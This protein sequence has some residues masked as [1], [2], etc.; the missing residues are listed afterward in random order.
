MLADTIVRRCA[1]H[2]PLHRMERIYARDGITLSRQTICGWHMTLAERLEPL[3]DAMWTDALTA[4]YLCVDATGVLVQHADKCKNGHFFVVAAPEKHVLFGFSEKHNSKAVDA[5]IGG[6]QGDLVA[7]AHTVYDHLFLSGAVRE[8]GC[9]AHTR[10]YFYK[11]LGSEPQRARVALAYIKQLFEL[12]RGIKNVSAEERLRVRKEKHAQIVDS[13]EKWCD[14]ESLDV[15]DESPLAKA[16]GY[17]R[18]QRA[19]LRVFLEEGKVPLDNNWSERELRRIAWGRDNWLFVGSEDGGHTMATFVSLI[20]SCQLHGIE[21]LAYLRDL[22]CLFPSWPEA[23]V[24][25]L[26]PLHWRTTLEREDVR[27][28]LAGNIFRRAA[29]G[30][31]PEKPGS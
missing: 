3:L 27:A 8:C 11:A 14:A 10:R 21:P 16:F 23:D 26:S 1:D 17:A 6:Y 4:P 2:T 28:R 30:E 24:L 5:L 31:L 22:L 20:A 12:E 15:L 9:W 29:L 7:D 19:A 13:F 25:E 18:N